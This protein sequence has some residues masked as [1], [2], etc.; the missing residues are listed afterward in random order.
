MGLP[1][2]AVMAQDVVD[3]FAAAN[4][5]F[6][7]LTNDQ[8]DLVRDGM[9]LAIVTTIRDALLTDAR[10]GFIAGDVAGTDSGGDTH[11]NITATG[12]RIT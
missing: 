6:D 8:K 11:G 12:G 3:N 7:G 5:D 4:S 1:T 2:A 9:V 10:V